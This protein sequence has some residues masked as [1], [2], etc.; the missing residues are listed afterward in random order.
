MCC[1]ATHLGGVRGPCL[2][3]GLTSHP[4]CPGHGV[5]QVSEPPG[6]QDSTG[7]GLSGQGSYSAATA[8]LPTGAGG[9]PAARAAADFMTSEPQQAAAEV[10]R[11]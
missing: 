8:R 6:S 11:R 4:A 9:S 2:P 10:E 5:R 1:P 3:P 7:Q